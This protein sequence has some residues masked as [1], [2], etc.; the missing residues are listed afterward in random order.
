M[1]KA[2]SQAEIEAAKAIVKAARARIEEDRLKH[3]ALKVAK[4]ELEQQ[5]LAEE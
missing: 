4:Y 5:R 2:T 1:A 3:E